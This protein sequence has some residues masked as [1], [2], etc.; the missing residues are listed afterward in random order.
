MKLGFCLLCN[1]LNAKACD[2]VFSFAEQIIILEDH[3][4]GNLNTMH[5]Q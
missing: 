5:L 3:H 1:N 2:G 4:K